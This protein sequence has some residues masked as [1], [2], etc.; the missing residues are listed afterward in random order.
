MP[1]RGVLQIPNLREVKEMVIKIIY[2]CNFL[3]GKQQEY[4]EWA[5]KA[6]PIFLAPE[7]LKKGYE[8]LSK[9]LGTRRDYKGK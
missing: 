2:T 3:P 1:R 6:V 4:L 5:Q 9:V 7:E 8:S